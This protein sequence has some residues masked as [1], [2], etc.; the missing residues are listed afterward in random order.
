MNP[1]VGANI[2]FVIPCYNGAEWLSE[3]LYSLLKQSVGDW[4]AVVVD[5]ASTDVDA[6]ARIAGSMQDG[7][8]R[9]IRHEKNR[10]LA[11]ARNTG[12]KAARTE[13]FVCVAPDDRLVPDHLERT[14]PAASEH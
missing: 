1:S 6:V 11:A 7:R 9:V 8:F 10:G 3:C 13:F 5:D 4:E 14:L 2:T 12:I